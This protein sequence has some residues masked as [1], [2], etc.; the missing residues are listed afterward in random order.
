[1]VTIPKRSGQVVEWQ[2]GKKTGHVC[3]FTLI[4]TLTPLVWSFT[5]C[6]SQEPKVQYDTW[7][8]I[9]APMDARL[10]VN[11]ISQ[12]RFL[13]T[14]GMPRISMIRKGNMRLERESLHGQ[15]VKKLVEPEKKSRGFR[16]IPS[17]HAS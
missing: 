6:H 9:Y 10:L 13:Y 7:R 4:C 8:V 2:S 3:W 14:G 16:P 17:H 1:M 5:L 12:D 11:P 15:R